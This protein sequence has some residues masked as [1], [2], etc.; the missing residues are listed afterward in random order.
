[1]ASFKS[2]NDLRGEVRRVAGGL[3]DV[4]LWRGDTE[5]AVKEMVSDDY[6][7]DFTAV[8]NE[9]VPVV[10]AA[11]ALPADEQAAAALTDAQRTAIHQQAE[12]DAKAAA[13]AQ[14]KADADVAASEDVTATDTGT[15]KKSGK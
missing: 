10:V 8:L 12:D 4:R 5:I 3:L 9:E 15:G 1:M 11:P 6:G 2:A 7:V 14:A 13:E